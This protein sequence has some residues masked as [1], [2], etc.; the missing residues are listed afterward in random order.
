MKKMFVLFL[1]FSLTTQSHSQSYYLTWQGC[2]GGSDIDIAEDIIEIKS[3]FLIAGAS[4]SNDGNVNSEHHGAVDGWLVKLD[5]QGSLIWEKCYGGTNSEV[6]TRIFQ[7]TEGNF[8]LLGDSDS[9][10]GDITNDPY[11]ESTD[12][13]IVK[14]DSIGTILWDRILGGGILDQ[15]WTGTLTDDGGIVAYGWSGSTDGDVS[16]DYGAYDMWMVKLNS[17]GEKEWD[18]SIGTDWF[19]YGQAIIQTSN[20]GF[21][22]GGSSAIGEGGNLT[23]D[24]FNY[25]A[26]AIL[27]KLDKDRNIEWQ[28]CYGGSDHDGITALLEIEDGYIFAGY[29]GSADGDLTGSGWHG[30]NDIWVV[31]IDSWGNIVWQKCFGGSADE[32]ID[33]LFQSANGDFIVTGVTTS[34]DGDVTGNHSVSEYDNDI[35]MIKISSEGELLSQQCIGGGGDERMDFGVVKKSDYDFVIAGQT[36]YGPSFDVQCTPHSTL[37]IPDFWV[38]EIKD[39]LTSI[40]TK[41]TVGI[42]VKV[43]PNPA[44]D[45]VKFEFGNIQN[46]QHAQLR[47]YDVFGSLLHSEAFVQGQ[48]EVVLDISSWPSG[49]YVAVVFSN[50]GVVGKSKFVVE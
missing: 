43:Y 36:D 39:T 45:K 6:F 33:Q 40:Q 42:E 12:Y 24:P 3:G 18:F 38:F 44:N 11:P 46:L 2:F 10:D 31:R 29:G 16:I 28:Q 41:P 5:K 25:N 23:C 35:W 9:S 14:I 20:G 13:W 4:K 48:K 49:M 34:K 50:G 22:C 1:F 27:V 19:D 7:D 30:E 15:L 32:W 37:G 8:L 21:L 26:E 47:C 17:E